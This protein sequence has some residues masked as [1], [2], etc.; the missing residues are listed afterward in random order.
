MVVASAY[1][2]TCFVRAKGIDSSKRACIMVPANVRGRIQPPLPAEYFGNCVA[3]CYAS[4]NVADLI[5]DDGIVV[6]A[7]AI[8]KSI[9]QISEILLKSPLNW[10]PIADMPVLN[11]A[12]SPK[13]RAYD[14]D[15]GLGRPTKVEIISLT[16][17]GVMSMEESRDEQGGIEIGIGFPKDEMDCF[18]KCFSDGLKLLS[19]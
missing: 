5:Q 3:P 8:G 17:K 18:K 19:E 16:K 4:A 2:W 15:F 10:K 14:I 13:F 7:E 12:G 6:A 1:V 9:A 11:I